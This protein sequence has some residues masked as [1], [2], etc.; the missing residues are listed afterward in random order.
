MWEESVQVQVYLSTDISSV[1]LQSVVT[2]SISC[3]SLAASV[4]SHVEDLG[5]SLI[6]GSGELHRREVRALSESHRLLWSLHWRGVLQSAW[7]RRGGGRPSNIIVAFLLYCTMMF[8]LQCT[9][10]CIELKLL[11]VP[12]FSLLLQKSCN[13]STNTAPL[14]QRI[15]SGMCLKF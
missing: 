3:I 10:L 8:P 6:P 15:C 11:I 5:A 9:N 14:F 12:V 1:T 13:C 7:Q 4:D 2:F